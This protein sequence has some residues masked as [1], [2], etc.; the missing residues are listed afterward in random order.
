MNVFVAFCSTVSTLPGGVL[1][2]FSANPR[3][4]A[5]TP[6]RDALAELQTFSTG[7]MRAPAG[8]VSVS[9]LAAIQP[10]LLS[11]SFTFSQVPFGFK[12]GHL[13]VL[14][15]DRDESEVRSGTLTDIVVGPLRERGSRHS[16]PEKGGEQDKKSKQLFHGEYLPC[17][18]EVSV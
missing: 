18:F 6:A 3:M 10:L 14:R 7:R 16:G 12:D 5:D 2:R 11:D 1:S 17:Y 9:E 15:D 13:G 8:F 4:A